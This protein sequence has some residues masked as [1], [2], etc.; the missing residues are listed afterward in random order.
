LRELVKLKDRQIEDYLGNDEKDKESEE[1]ILKENK[2]LRNQ[3]TKREFE[4]KEVVRT[5]KFYSEEKNR[6]EKELEK[7]HREND[8]LI[9]HKNPS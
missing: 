5:L 4:M 1:R 7:L 6:L 2:D 3:I 9:G 8:Q